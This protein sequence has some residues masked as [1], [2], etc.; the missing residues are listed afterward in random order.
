MQS[1]GQRTGGGRAAA[2]A[3]RSLRDPRVL[4]ADH[5][6]PVLATVRTGDRRVAVAGARYVPAGCVVADGLHASGEGE[7]AALLLDG[8]VLQP[9][10]SRIRVDRR[11]AVGAA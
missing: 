9:A 7:S 1:A 5:P 11:P 8:A 3:A 10:V 6:A 2:R 4:A